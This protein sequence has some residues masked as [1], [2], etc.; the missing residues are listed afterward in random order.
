MSA[1]PNGSAPDIEIDPRTDII[2]KPMPNGQIRLM[3]PMAD[4]VYCLG[5]LEMAKHIILSFQAPQA[6][7]VQPVPAAALQNIPE[8]E[9]QTR[10]R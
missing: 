9:F 8:P 5:M 7:N 2:I 1:G 10:K 3:A 6:T 4:K